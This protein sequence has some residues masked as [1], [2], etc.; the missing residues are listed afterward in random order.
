MGF[1]FCLYL[2]LFSC[3]PFW[4]VAGSSGTAWNSSGVWDER[5]LRRFFLKTCSGCGNELYPL[6]NSSENTKML[7]SKPSGRQWLPCPSPG[8]PCS[9]I[10]TFSPKMLNVLLFSLQLQ[11]LS[12]GSG[13]HTQVCREISLPR[14]CL[15]FPANPSPQIPPSWILWVSLVSLGVELEL[16]FPRR[17]FH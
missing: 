15:G 2:S 7:F 1:F 9:W 6:F 4:I 5:C 14:E 3:N 12:G 17:T 11:T 10:S 8:K 16:S 13:L